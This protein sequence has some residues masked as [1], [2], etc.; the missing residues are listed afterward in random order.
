[1]PI[2]TSSM[3]PEEI[4]EK[5]PVTHYGPTWRKGEDG[6][7][8]IPEHSLGWEI[9]GWCSEY[10]L[11]PNSPEEEQK[12][13]RFTNEQFRFML[14]WYAIDS[15]GRFTSRIGLLQRIKGWG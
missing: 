15:T 7:F 13:F 12:P 3:T 2:D 1:M 14:W 10:L 5:F 11:D 8:D 6:S 4:R 9:A